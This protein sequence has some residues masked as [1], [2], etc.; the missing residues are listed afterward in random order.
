[1]G[2]AGPTRQK[3]GEG[4]GSGLRGAKGAHNQVMGEDWEL[5][6]LGTSN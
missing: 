6:S 2:Q 4:R 1:M 5:G 3:G